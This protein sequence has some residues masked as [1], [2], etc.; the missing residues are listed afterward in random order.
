L[1]VEW[2]EY[3]MAV[4]IEQLLPS[5][6]PAID[7]RFCVAPMMD[8]TD[9]HCRYWLRLIFPEALLY[10][11]M[12]TTDALL[13]GDRGRLLAYDPAEH[14]VAV[15]LGG[16]DPSS[17]ASCARMAEDWGYDEVN[18]NVG[19]PSDRVQSGS[20][21]ACLMA[22]PERVAACVDAMRAAVNIP[23]TVKTRTGIDELDD[24]V[25]LRHFISTVASGG[26]GTFVIHAR[27]AWLQGMSPKENREIPPLDYSRVHRVKREFPAL[28]IVINGGIKTV[29]EAMEQLRHVDGVMIGRE[30]YQNPYA[31]I[32][33]RQSVYG[34]PG[35]LPP[36]EVIVGRYIE[37]MRRQV[38]QGIYL[39][40]MTRHILG[41]FQGVPGAKR[42]RRYLSEKSCRPGA[43]VGVV[44]AALEQVRQFTD[45]S[46][47]VSSESKNQ[48]TQKARADDGGAGG[49]ACFV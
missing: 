32:G 42:W 14:P 1:K 44:E 8:W 45:I 22:E 31:L 20:F 3:P 43:D 40:H 27:K 24:Y 25:H 28:Q 35:P 49:Q 4:S 26:C 38:D 7:R 41:L 13:Y 16:S 30:A 6:A 2:I 34:E 39:K 11:E 12:I 18:I 19:C 47:G 10:T 37:Y 23:V 36:R 29:G 15:Q 33:L 5:R 21:G 46:E 48:E 9:R 17:M